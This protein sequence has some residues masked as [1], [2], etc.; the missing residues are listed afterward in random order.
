MIIGHV[1]SGE[2]MFETRFFEN[3]PE[4]T[5]C[6]KCDT[7]L[8]YDYI[9]NQI[10]I[11]KKQKN[12]V[13]ATYELVKL[14]SERFVEFI[15]SIVKPAPLFRQVSENPKYFYYLP[16]RVVPFD[17]EKRKVIF[18]N[19]CNLCGGYMSIAGAAPA[20]LKINALP[21]EGLFRTDLVF[22]SRKWPLTIVD[23][24]LKGALQKQKF[25]GVHFGDVYSEDHIWP[26]PEYKPNR[27]VTM[28]PRRA[29]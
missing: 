28:K 3:A 20:P 26:P 8:R 12:D 18:E 29:A 21:G 13:V 10:E 19:P 5:R 14:Y 7:P 4:G 6:P 2:D 15:E 25:R 11:S 24:K 16:E 1:V 27:R 17:A 22:G 23:P 9:P